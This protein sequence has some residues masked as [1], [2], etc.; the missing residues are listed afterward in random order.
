[1]VLDRLVRNGA[2]ILVVEHNTDFIR[3][4]D[5]IVDLG[6]GAGPMGGMLLYEGPPAGIYNVKS[7]LTG[8]A[9]K[10]KKHSAP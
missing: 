1:M 8:K 7:S 3:A 4:A 5:W 10:R 9:L 2:T 6:P